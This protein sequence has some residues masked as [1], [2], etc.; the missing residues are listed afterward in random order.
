MIDVA[1]P[2]EPSAHIKAL[3]AGTDYFRCSPSRWTG[4]P[5]HKEWQ[6][7]LVCSEAVHLLVNFNLMDDPW[8]EGGRGPQIGR[9]I[10]LA[11]VLGAGWGG[12]VERFDGGEIDVTPGRIDARFGRSTLRFDQ[13]RYHVSVALRDRPIAAELSLA[14]ITLP[15]LSPNRPLSRDRRISWLVVPRL[16]AHGTISVGDRALPVTAAPAYHDHNWG[17][18]QWGDDFSWEWCSALPSDPESEWSA[19]YVRM[20]DLGRAVVRY[21]GLTLWRG[22]EPLRVFVD[23]EIRVE[24]EGR[25]DLRRPLKIPRVMAMLSPGAESDV[26]RRI[27]V[28]ARGGGDEL[29]LRFLSEDA[30]QVVTPGEIDPEGVTV[31][32]EVS[33]RVELEGRVRGADVHMEGPGVFELLR[34]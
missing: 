31:L 28:L 29:A 9:L 24:H 13:G 27:E 12:D 7:F 10:V 8:A 5:D 21:Q 14:P 2:P 16:V 17:H 1:A 23:E 25:L 19:V 32:N 33:G 11:R 15:M 22:G 18:F 34:D 6:H 3:L 4:R 20:M 30:A 26:P